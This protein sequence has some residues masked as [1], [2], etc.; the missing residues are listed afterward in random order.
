MCGMVASCDHFGR[1][2]YLHPMEAACGRG[3]RHAACRH[4][5]ACRQ[6]SEIGSD[7]SALATLLAAMHGMMWRHDVRPPSDSGNAGLKKPA[8]GFPARAYVFLR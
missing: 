7:G 1:E 8:A 2:P 3:F 6:K 4:V 5:R